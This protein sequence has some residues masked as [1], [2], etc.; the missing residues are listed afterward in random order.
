[1]LYNVLSYTPG[2]NEGKL[3]VRKKA[4]SSG[5]TYKDNQLLCACVVECRRSPNAFLEYRMKRLVGI[6]DL[7]KRNVRH[8]M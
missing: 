1:M 2:K 7:I 4:V 5:S 3:R 8:V 6:F